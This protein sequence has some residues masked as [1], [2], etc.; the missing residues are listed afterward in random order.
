MFPRRVKEAFYG[1]GSNFQPICAA[2][3]AG[4]GRGGGLEAALRGSGS[5]PGRTPAAGRGRGGTSGCCSPPAGEACYQY[6][7]SRQ[8]AQSIRVGDVSL[9]P[10]EDGPEGTR[11]AARRAARRGRRSPGLRMRVLQAGRGMSIVGAVTA[12]IRQCGR[13]TALEQDGA[14]FRFFA[15]VQP[16]R[17]RHAG[18][19]PEHPVAV[20]ENRPAAVH[21]LWA[22]FGRRRAGAGGFHPHGGGERYEILLCHDFYCGGD[23]AF[24]WAAAPAGK[25]GI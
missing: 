2:G 14:V 13:E 19:H 22:A 12:A 16:A 24:R 25:G 20:R 6:A 4:G 11:A 3:G 10:A 18:A 5:A 7:L 8:N 9:S 23:P 21:L 15:C 17:L 1:Y